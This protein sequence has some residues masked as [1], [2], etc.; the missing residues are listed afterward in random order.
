MDGAGQKADE[1][2]TVPITRLTSAHLVASGVFH[3]DPSA[4]PK[5]VYSAMPIPKKI[6]LIRNRGSAELS[7]IFGVPWKSLPNF[8]QRG[9]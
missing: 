9:R 3:A 4:D 5:K 7:F 8:T 1:T 6:L 2:P